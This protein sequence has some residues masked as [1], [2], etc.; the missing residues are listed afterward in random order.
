MRRR[1]DVSVGVLMSVMMCWAV[2][3]ASPTIGTAQTLLGNAEA[4]RSV[5][6]GKGVCHY[7]HGVDG[8]RDKRPKLEV[9]TAALIAR[10]NP[11]PSDLRNP[12]SLRL[13]TDKARA[14]L[15]REG[16]EGT[17]MFPDTTMTDRELADTLAYL[18]VLRREGSRGAQR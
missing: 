18:A 1:R 12:K 13:K 17:A 6:N 14:K 4:G 3:D 7:C 10:L 5:F 16:H 9:D 8:Y 2:S 11:P 15:I